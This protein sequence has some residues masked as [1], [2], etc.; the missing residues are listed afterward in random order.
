[1]QIVEFIAVLLRTNS[2]G[3]RR[4]LMERGAIKTVLDLFFR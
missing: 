1:M 4:E 2:E 3:A